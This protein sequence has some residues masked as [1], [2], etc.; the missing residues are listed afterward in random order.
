MTDNWADLISDFFIFF[1]LP[2]LCFKMFESSASSLTLDFFIFS[3]LS[4]LSVLFLLFMSLLTILT[5]SL[6]LFWS[7][8]LFF[9]P[10]FNRLFLTHFSCL[11]S[12]L[13]LFRF[14]S[15]SVCLSCGSLCAA[16]LLCPVSFGL[17]ITFCPCVLMPFSMALNISY[18]P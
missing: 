9:C 16:S 2:V 3:S 8:S 14:F 12:V 5:L 7:V 4:R 15:D 13:F 17:F 1:F 6:G 18:I 11:I 10:F